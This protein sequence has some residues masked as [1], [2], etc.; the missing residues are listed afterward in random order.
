MATKFAYLNGT[1]SGAPRDGNGLP[2]C[3]D[4]SRASCGIRG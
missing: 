1:L 2:N 3:G 4:S